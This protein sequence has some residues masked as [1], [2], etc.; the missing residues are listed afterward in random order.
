MIIEVSWERKAADVAGAGRTI[1]KSTAL[2]PAETCVVS[3]AGIDF[4]V[5]QTA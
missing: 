2:A 4:Q 3:M 1:G 5:G